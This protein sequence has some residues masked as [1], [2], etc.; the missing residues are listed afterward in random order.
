MSCRERAAKDP[1]QLAADVEMSMHYVAG[2]LSAC[3]VGDLERAG[4][5]LRRADDAIDQLRLNV[6]A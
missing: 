5:M 4:E 1:S 2:A 6:P 3:G